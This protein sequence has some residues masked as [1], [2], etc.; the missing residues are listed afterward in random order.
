MSLTAKHYIGWTEKPLEMRISDHKSGS[1]AKILAALVRKGIS[2][3]V[4]R[5]WENETGHFERKLKNMKNSRALCP[6][7]GRRKR[8]FKSHKRLSEEQNAKHPKPM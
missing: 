4:T 1:G 8:K 2:F 3:K 7:C 6:C 5:I